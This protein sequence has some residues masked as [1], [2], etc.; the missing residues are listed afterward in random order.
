MIFFM[1]FIFLFSDIAIAQP[2]QCPD[3]LKSNSMT[4]CVNSCNN[5]FCSFSLLHLG[6]RYNANFVTY[7]NRDPKRPLEN[8]NGMEAFHGYEAPILVDGSSLHI[9][10]DEKPDWSI[11]VRV[12]EGIKGTPIRYGGNADE[13]IELT[14]LRPGKY[15]IDIV[16][17]PRLGG[18]DSANYEAAIYVLPTVQP[19]DAGNSPQSGKY[20]GEL[21][22]GNR[23]LSA[24]GYVQIFHDRTITGQSA[25][26]LANDSVDWFIVRTRTPGTLKV[27]SRTWSF[28]GE[29]LAQLQV[30]S[31]LD[32]NMQ[33]TFPAGGLLVDAGQY[34]VGFGELSPAISGEFSVKYRLELSFQP[35]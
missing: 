3:P 17:G 7:T 27:V 22:S 24:D 23:S 6:K 13:D 2:N 5:Y 8:V 31:S 32:G 4:A 21:T 10:L 16:H 33:G 19:D 20:L 14:N 35:N 25:A 15:Y 9:K 26:M 34:Y 28:P 11:F 29:D 30:L 18:V 12:K 1:I